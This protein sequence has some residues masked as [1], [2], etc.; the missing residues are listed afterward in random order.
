M[1]FPEFLNTLRIDYAKQYIKN[2]PNAKQ[3][4]IARSCGFLSASSFNNIFRKITGMTPKT[5]V[6]KMAEK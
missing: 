1:S 5:W 2:H 4:E 6:F 3:E